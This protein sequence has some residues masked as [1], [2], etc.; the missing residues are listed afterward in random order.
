MIFF[1]FHVVN[2][3]SKNISPKAWIHYGRKGNIFLRYKQMFEEKVERLLFIGEKLP[4]CDSELINKK[5]LVA[6][7]ANEVP[8][9]TILEM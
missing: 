8:M 4:E 9:S 5:R 2:A 1:V 7:A 6:F 3:E